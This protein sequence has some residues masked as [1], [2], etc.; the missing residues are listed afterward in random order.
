L[1]PIVFGFN[2]LASGGEDIENAD[3]SLRSDFWGSPGSDEDEDEDKEEL[4]Q[5]AIPVGFLDDRFLSGGEELSDDR[6]NAVVP[7]SSHILYTPLH[8]GNWVRKR[9]P[10]SL[11]SSPVVTRA[12]YKRQ[13]SNGAVT[14][15]QC[16]GS[17]QSGEGL[18]EDVDD[19]V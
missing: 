19:D 17:P 7:D 10:T 4:S 14:F 5:S 1:E 15:S 16:I 11:N 8:L 3:T 13:K 18:F 6:E 2:E 9:P 12:A